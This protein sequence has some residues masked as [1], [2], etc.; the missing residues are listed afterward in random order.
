MHNVDMKPAWIP[1]YEAIKTTNIY[2]FMS[3]LNMHDVK[4]FHQWTTQH[5]QD[6]W[7]HRVCR[8]PPLRHIRDPSGFVYL[9]IGSRTHLSDSPLF[10]KERG[11]G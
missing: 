5:Y 3:A 7:P 10:I 9:F 1:T 4:T 2:Q 6:F 11:R 8:P